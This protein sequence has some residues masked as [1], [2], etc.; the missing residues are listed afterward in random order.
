M[1]TDL[2]GKLAERLRAEIPIEYSPASRIV[3]PGRVED[4][5]PESRDSGFMLRM[6]RNDDLRLSRH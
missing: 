2:F 4:A 6:P 1:K 5:N 3:I